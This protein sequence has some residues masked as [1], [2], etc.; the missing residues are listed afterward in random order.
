MRRKTR[1]FLIIVFTLLTL[2]IIIN[3]F[4][5][6]YNLTHINVIY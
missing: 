3:C 5:L 4:L 2:L 1:I 6:F